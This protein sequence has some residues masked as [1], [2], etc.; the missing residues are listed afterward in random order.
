[1][2][3]R[4]KKRLVQMK[5]APALVAKAAAPRI[6]AQFRADATTKRGNVP[7]YGDKG[8]VPITATPRPEA[9]VVSG[10][11]WCVEKAQEKGQIDGW[12]GILKEE[13]QRIFVGGG[14]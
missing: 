12:V 11:A 13:A 14:R 2:F 1:M 7:S 10:P 5:A 9:V 6:Q 4:T 8:D 3:E